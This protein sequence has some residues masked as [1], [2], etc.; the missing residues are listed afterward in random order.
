M[1][2]A[3]Y[4]DSFACI[5]TIWELKDGYN[6]D[7]G[8]LRGPSWVD[9]LAENHIVTNFAKSGTAF[10]FSYELFLNNFKDFDLNIVH[11]TS[12]LRIHVKRMFPI[13]FFGYVWTDE[14]KDMIKKRPYYEEQ[15][16]EIKIMESIKV[17]QQEWADWDMLRHLQHLMVDN[18]WALKKNTIVLPGFEDSI[19]Q[20]TKNFNYLAQQEMRLVSENRFDKFNWWKLNCKRQC[21]FS[22]ENNVIIAEKIIN[23]ID[24][25]IPN[26]YIGMD[27]HELKKPNLDFDFYVAEH[28]IN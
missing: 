9:I 23:A 18:L 1:K 14:M 19:R 6:V 28:I 13:L 16:T 21:H 8:K 4:G 27:L 15:E 26:T 3:I 25:N 24:N 11:V 22:K 20:T 17:Y 10:Q 2:I 7:E 5:N 12:P